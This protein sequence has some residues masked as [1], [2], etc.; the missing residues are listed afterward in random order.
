M[1]DMSPQLNGLRAGAD[2][3][4]SGVIVPPMEGYMNL[5]VQVREGGAWHTVRMMVCDVD[6]GYTMH[7]LL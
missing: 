2:G 1:P 6:S 3:W 4:Y 7:L 5:A